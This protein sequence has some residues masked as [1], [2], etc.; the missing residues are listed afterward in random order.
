MKSVE[1]EGKRA[2]VEVSGKRG[3]RGCG[4]EWGPG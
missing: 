4:V 2:T 1:D 3:V